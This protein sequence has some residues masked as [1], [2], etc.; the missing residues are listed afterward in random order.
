MKVIDRIIRN[1]KEQSK[2]TDPGVWI[3]MLRG[4]SCNPKEI[5]KIVQ[6][7]MIHIY[8]LWAY[9]D[10]NIEESRKAEAGIL[11][12]E[13]KL[14]ALHS[15]GIEQLID[16]RPME[17]KLLGTCRDFSLFF[18]SLLRNKGYAARARCG[19]ANYFTPEKNEDHWIVEYFQEE[20][21]KWIRM[22]AQIDEIQ[23]KR[24]N[25]TSNPEDLEKAAFLFG[26]EAWRDCRQGLKDPETF[27]IMEWWGMDYVLSNFLLDIASL[28]KRPL[29]PWNL[30]DGL[31]NMSYQDLDRKELAVLDTLAD[32]ALDVDEHYD[33]IEK[34]Y[35]QYFKVPED[36][37]EVRSYR[38]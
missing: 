26:G 21:R 7:N 33:E 20:K 36:L 11:T 9:Q 6:R 17:K 15:M 18:C 16:P 30:W 5:R 32:L 14:S 29:L 2:L 1:Y 27:G 35:Q 19:F 8:W 28:M 37:G 24:L 13:E 3:D 23:R 12:M 22:D 25:M 38:N 34:I 31:K 4:I 10:L